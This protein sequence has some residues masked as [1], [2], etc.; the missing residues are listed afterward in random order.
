MY[1]LCGR[2]RL[3]NPESI[4]PTEVSKTLIAT[5]CDSSASNRL[6]LSRTLYTYTAT[7]LCSRMVSIACPNVAILGIAK[8]EAAMADAGQSERVAAIRALALDVWSSEADANEWLHRPHG[9]LRSQSL[10]RRL[11]PKKVL[12]ASCGCYKGCITGYR[13]SHS[14]TAN[15]AVCKPWRTVASHCSGCRRYV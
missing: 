1:L 12:L 10:W 14:C 9:Q 13:C 7:P 4:K 8:E 6:H 5:I 3:V 15:P 2:V 11:R